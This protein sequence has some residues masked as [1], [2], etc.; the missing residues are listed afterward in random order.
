MKL[1]HKGEKMKVVLVTAVVAMFF[2][3]CT[4]TSKKLTAQ[5]IVV[6]EKLMANSEDNKDCSVVVGN[7]ITVAPNP[8]APGQ[9]LSIEKPLVCGTASCPISLPEAEGAGVCMPLDVLK[10]K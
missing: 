5:D 9:L 3:S 8:M 7:I 6:G 2:V 10:K 1:I 4:S